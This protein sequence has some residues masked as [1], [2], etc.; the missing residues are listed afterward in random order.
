M[1]ATQKIGLKVREARK[2]KGWTQE[3]LKEALCKELPLGSK[4]SRQWV[5]NLESKLLKR[6]MSIERRKV[7]QQILEINFS[8]ISDTID[9]IPSQEIASHDCLPLL[10][11]LTA[12][13]LSNLTFEQLISLCET[14][15][16][17]QKIGIQMSF[18]AETL[19]AHQQ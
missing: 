4:V 10:R 7:L 5:A 6:P 18:S 14:D 2:G 17:L 12:T 15:Y 16:K 1:T 13:G 11:R 9:N 3:Q 8:N 19:P